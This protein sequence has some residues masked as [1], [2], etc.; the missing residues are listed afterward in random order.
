VLVEMF[1]LAGARG[2]SPEG[3]GPTAEAIDGFLA[4]PDV[5]VV[6]VGSSH[7]TLLGNAFRQYLRRRKLPVVLP[8]PD[9]R[10]QRGCAAEIREHLQRTL[11][12]RL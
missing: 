7:A 12:I 1:R 9:R 10:D 2:A 6:L 4:E 3:E 8:V 5:G 11:G